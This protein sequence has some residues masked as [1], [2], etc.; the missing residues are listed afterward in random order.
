MECRYVKSM[1]VRISPHVYSSA[2][3]SVFFTGPHCAC[4]L[5]SSALFPRGWLKRDLLNWCVPTGTCKQHAR[6][7]L[8]LSTIT[9]TL[10]F[11]FQF[12]LL[13]AVL[14]SKVLHALPLVCKSSDHVHAPQGALHLVKKTD[15]TTLATTERSTRKIEST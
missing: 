11:F 4:T 8:I 13:A 3:K 14:F 5:C 12:L 6:L 9:E 2:I 10:F 1:L 15:S 7:L